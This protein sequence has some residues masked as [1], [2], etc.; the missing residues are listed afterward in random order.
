MTPSINYSSNTQDRNY[1][2][3][4]MYLNYLSDDEATAI[5]ELFGNLDSQS[6]SFSSRSNF[7]K[8]NF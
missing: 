6:D 8:I 1:N 3:D 7:E 5:Y 2:D 4:S